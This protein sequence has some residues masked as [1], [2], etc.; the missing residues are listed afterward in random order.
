MRIERE[1]DEEYRR[2]P[3]QA[4]ELNPTLSL[5][6]GYQ[7]V[8]RIG[9]AVVDP[10]APPTAGSS[11]PTLYEVRFFFAD[12]AEERANPMMFGSAVTS[13]R[14]DEN[15]RALAMKLI[16][17]RP[18]EVALDLAETKLVVADVGVHKDVGGLGA[19]YPDETLILFR[20]KA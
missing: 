4:T 5:I 12:D 20:P 14:S 13:N 7:P 9:E 18:T 3:A 2:E 17:E 16:R 11:A 19:S 10:F 1:F 15:L 8:A 6:Q